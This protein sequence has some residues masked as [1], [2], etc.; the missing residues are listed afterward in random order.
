MHRPMEGTATAGIP[1]K[2][3][4]HAGSQ[5]GPYKEPSIHSSPAEASAMASSKVMELM[6]K[7]SG[8][9][10]DQGTRISTNHSHSPI[11]PQQ[12]A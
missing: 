1:K 2:W 5:K 6:G 4:P 7:A 9:C 3:R 11:L 8:T 10:R 12:S